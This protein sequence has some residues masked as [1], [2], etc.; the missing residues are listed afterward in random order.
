MN[1]ISISEN[2][3]AIE[4][5]GWDRVWSWKKSLTFPRHSIRKVYRHDGHLMPPWFRCPGTALPRVIIAGTYYGRGRK[6]FWS[7]RFRKSALVFDLEDAEYTRV[8]VDV[9]NP[10]AILARLAQGP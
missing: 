4:I 10:D 7:I 3:V 8:A 9:D 6:E 5:A 1:T 2:A